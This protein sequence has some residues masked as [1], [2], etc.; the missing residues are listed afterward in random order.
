MTTKTYTLKKDG[1]A[2]EAGEQALKAGQTLT[3]RELYGEDL[4]A[5][6]AYEGE[7]QKSICMIAVMTGLTM[8]EAG[9]LSVPDFAALN[10][11]TRG[12]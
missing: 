12:L 4:I 9:R 8:K 2:G 1:R 5:S 7:A 10:A 6:D 3:V 11:L